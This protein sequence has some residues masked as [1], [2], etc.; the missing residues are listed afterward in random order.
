MCNAGFRARVLHTARTLSHRRYQVA[1]LRWHGASPLSLSTC[2]KDFSPGSTLNIQVCAANKLLSELPDNEQAQ[3]ARYGEKTLLLQDSV[4]FEPGDRI[5][6]VYFPTTSFILLN[7]SVTPAG[8]LGLGLVGQEGVLAA[9]LTDTLPFAPM[10]AKVLGSGMA[11]RFALPDFHELI[12]SAPVL[13]HR[14]E[15]YQFS[16]QRE[17]M[18]NA[19]CAVYHVLDMRLAYWLLMLHDRAATGP[20]EFTHERLARILGVR[21]SGVSTAA[22]ILQKHRLIDYSRGRIVILNR[23]GLEAAAC[24]CHTQNEKHAD[25][26]ATQYR[27]SA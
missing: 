2:Y 18:H 4:L 9:T 7:A 27:L 6:S 10:Q 20:M 25:G 15:V 17:L 1:Y 8:T 11:L 23:R 26:L 24:E 22:G 12:R 14:L 16:H 13:K 21:R 5:Y 19:A 3:L